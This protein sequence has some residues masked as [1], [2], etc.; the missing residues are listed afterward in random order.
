MDTVSLSSFE[1]P[2]Q[3]E[4]ISNIISRTSTNR[5]DVR[6]AVLRGLDLSFARTVLDLG[7]GFGFMTETLAGRVAPDALI[8]GVDVCAA[9]ETPYLERVSSTGRT[10]RFIHRCIDRQLSWP[11]ASFDLVVASYALYFFPDALPETARVLTPQG[12]FLTVTHTE[13]SCRDLL[14]AIGL[15]DADSRLLAL[16]RRFSAESAGPQLERWFGEVARLDYRNSLTF[17]AAHEDDLLTYLRFKLPL[18]LRDVAPGAE[19]PEPFARAVQASLSR[20]GRVTLEKNDTAFRCTRPR[21]T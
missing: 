21:C 8:V 15:G 6:D 10:G 16:V 3:H 2:S 1:S 18:L 20:Q 11:D 4:V 12:L 9:N 19:L 17:D 13:S 14:R 7:C 5:T